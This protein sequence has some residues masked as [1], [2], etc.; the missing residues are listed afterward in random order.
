MAGENR[1]IF[2]L[3]AE[4]AA[5]FHLHH[6]NALGRKVEQPG[7]RAVNV[8]GALHRAP[9]R[10]AGLRIRDGEHAVRLDIELLLR[11][12]VVLALD[13]SAPPRGTPNRRPRAGRDSVL[14]TLSAPQITARRSSDSSMVKTGGSGSTVDADPAAGLFEQVPVVVGEEDDRFFRVVDGLAREVGLIVDDQRDDVRAGNVG[15]GDDDELV[16]GH[17]RLE[18]DA[19]DDAARRLAAHGDAVQHPWQRQ[20][21]DVARLAGDLAAAFLA[22]NGADQSRAHGDCRTCRALCATCRGASG[23][24][25]CTCD[26]GVLSLQPGRRPAPNPRTRDPRPTETYCTRSDRRSTCRGGTTRR[27]AARCRA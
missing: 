24:V 14:K 19:A 22:R 20:V 3:A 12:G 8:V 16:P 26:A 7:E 23:H 25:L 5:R 27:A 15:G 6:A 13:D 17:A 10:H 18:L 11:A 9:H 2:L 1:R 21:V 4:P